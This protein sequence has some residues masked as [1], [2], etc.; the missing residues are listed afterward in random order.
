MKTQNTLTADV[1][2]MIVSPYEKPHF[3]TAATDRSL[4]VPYLLYGSTVSTANVTMRLN[5]ICDYAEQQ[6]TQKVANNPGVVDNIAHKLVSIAVHG[7]L[8]IRQAH[9]D[10]KARL[11]ESE[12]YMLNRVFNW[13]Y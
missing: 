1:R 11:E 4:L 10:A 13:G 6:L 8:R 7:S 5:A 12:Y 2:Y 9:I 3:T